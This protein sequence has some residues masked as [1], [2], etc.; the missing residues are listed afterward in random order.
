MANVK[1]ENKK[2]A[3]C[4]FEEFAKMLLYMRQQIPMYVFLN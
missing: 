1:N 2:I 4:L 3:A